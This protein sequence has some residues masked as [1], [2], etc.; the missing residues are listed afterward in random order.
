MTQAVTDL[1]LSYGVPFSDYVLSKVQVVHRA[2]V[3]ER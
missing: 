2:Q 1:R 3:S